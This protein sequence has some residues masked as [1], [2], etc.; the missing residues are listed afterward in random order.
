[1]DPVI[2]LF[3]TI[4]YLALLVWGIVLAQKNGWNNS[5]NLIL[6]VISGLIY[7]NGIL[8]AGTLIGEGGLLK[9]LNAV[10]FWAHAFFTPLLVIFAWKTVSGTG[11]EWARSKWLKY[12]TYLVFLGLVVLELATEVSGLELRAKREYGVLS[13]ENAAQGGGPPLMVLVVTVFL[14]I[15]SIIVWK[16]QKWPWFFVGTVLMGVGSAVEFPVE[17]AAVVNAFELIL[18]LSLMATKQFQDRRGE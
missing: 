11:V 2:Y 1:M 9:N 14:L 12:G 17:S 16:K 4:A 18:L 15:A 13:Y 3:F 10:R 7:D 8:A 5:A 6:L